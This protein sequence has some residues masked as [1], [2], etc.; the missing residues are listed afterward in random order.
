VG[1]KGR[2]TWH[3]SVEL[4]IVRLGVLFGTLLKQR[5]HQNIIIEIQPPLL[6][7]IQ[8]NSEFDTERRAH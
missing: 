7:H 2:T 4:E 8:E 6:P 5:S 1:I 3:E